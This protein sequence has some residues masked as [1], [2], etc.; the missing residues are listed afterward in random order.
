MEFCSILWRDKSLLERAD[1]PDEEESYFEDL[2]LTMIIDKITEN[3]DAINIRKYFYYINNDTDT[4]KYRQDIL[5]DI[6]QSDV[7]KTFSNFLNE[8]SKCNKLEDYSNK[9]TYPWQKMG[10]YLDYIYEY[11]SVITKLH[12]DLS[13][14]HLNSQGLTDFKHWLDNYIL[15]QSFIELK[16][17]ADNL[18]K[19]INKIKYSLQFEEDRVIVHTDVP[20]TN[21]C[22]SIREMFN[23]PDDEEYLMENPFKGV[24]QMS[25]LEQRIIDVLAQEYPQVFKKLESF[26]YNN[27][28]PIPMVIKRLAEE[29]PFY[30]EYLSFIRKLENMG[31]HF[32]FP[33]VKDSSKEFYFMELYDLALGI[34]N[35]ESNIDT[36]T[37]SAYYTNKEKFMVVTGPNQGGKTTF[38]RAVGQLIYFSLLGLMVPCQKAVLPRF[39]GIITYFSKEELLE[40][41]MG[42][43]KEELTRI[44]P[45]MLQEF[46][47][48][49]V[50]INELFTTAGTYDAIYMGKRVIRHFIKSGCYGIYVT[51]IVELAEED[52]TIVSMVASLDK[53]N[54]EKR[55][56]K[57]NRMPAEGIGYV[58]SLVMKYNLTYDDIKEVLKTCL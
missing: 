10:H 3:E 1:K 43:L 30:T 26:Y 6:M 21:Y 49:F 33:Q 50:I 12:K 37:N 29:L 58:N 18:I 41:G 7:F 4:I 23:K 25:L 35:M 52:E 17:E 40:T 8:Q 13:L 57:I 16:M 44:R 45:M 55:S 2:N 51:H 15:R 39:D 38:A 22:K 36:I 31:L 54:K 5:K 28:D 11:C 14:C 27:T 56:Y 46:N 32:C 48:Q 47:N 53:E 24:F 20:S 19:E 9:A 34:K 42:K